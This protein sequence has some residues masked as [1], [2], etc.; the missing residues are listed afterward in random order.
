MSLKISPSLYKFFIIIYL[1]YFQLSLKRFTCLAKT[2][3]SSN[4]FFNRGFFQKHK[5]NHIKNFDFFF[6]DYFLQRLVK[7]LSHIWIFATR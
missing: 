1:I 5:L 7:L 6:L 3:L 2:C 4:Q